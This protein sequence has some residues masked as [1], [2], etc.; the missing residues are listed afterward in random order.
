MM[1]MPK[2]T[3]IKGIWLLLA[4]MLAHTCLALLARMLAPACLHISGLHIQE[5]E[6]NC[7]TSAA[8]IAVSIHLWSVQNCV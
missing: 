8:N 7:F 1:H 6:Q 5:A 3:S 4:H 2:M